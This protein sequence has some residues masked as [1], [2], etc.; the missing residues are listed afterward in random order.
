[1]DE[2]SGGWGIIGASLSVR[3]INGT[4]AR[5]RFVYMYGTIRYDRHPQRRPYI[6]HNT[7]VVL[8]HTPR[9]TCRP[10][11]VCLRTPLHARKRVPRPLPAF[12]CCKIRGSEDEAASVQHF[13]QARHT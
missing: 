13:A 9:N 4:C 7:L 6:I 11:V 10:H 2:G 12:Q 1:M 5:A 8:I 3:H